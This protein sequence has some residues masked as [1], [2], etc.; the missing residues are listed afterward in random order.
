MKAVVHNE[1]SDVIYIV[2]GMHDWQ[3]LEMA[4]LLR[5][6]LVLVSSQ[7]LDWLV[8]IHTT[9]YRDISTINSFLTVS[10]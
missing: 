7:D 3:L 5:F 4:T 9:Q 2:N 8:V 1:L 6:Q 10:C